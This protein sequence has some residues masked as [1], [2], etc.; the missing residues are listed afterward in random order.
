M[1]EFALD[2]GG[3]EA[4]GFKG[5]TGDCA[6]RAAAIATGLSYQTVYD[7]VN[8]LAQAERPR[9][10]KKRSSSREGVWPRTLGRFLEE[11]MGFAWHPTMEIGSG[12]QV[13]LR[14]DELP[15]GRLVVRVS[16]HYA[17]VIDGVLH[18]LQD[19]S[20]NG[21]RCVYGFWKAPSHA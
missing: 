3:R 20:R 18:D 10:K 9:G 14:A 13:H 11:N 19:C 17:A 4:A 8:C 21:T 1:I 12:C 7:C 15:A 6:V 2:D 16:R 5:Q